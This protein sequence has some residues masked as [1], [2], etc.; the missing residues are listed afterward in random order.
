MKNKQIN[1][2]VDGSEYSLNIQAALANGTLVPAVVASLGTIVQFDGELYVLAQ[3][4]N[5][6]I[7]AIHLHTSNRYTTAGTQVKDSDDISK[8]ELSDAFGGKHSDFIKVTKLN[9]RDFIG[10]VTNAVK[11]L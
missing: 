5:K 11:S 7:H 6:V 9:M 3:T 8:A 4:G 1:V 10:P 2:N